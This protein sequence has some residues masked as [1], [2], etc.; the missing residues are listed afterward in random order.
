MWTQ[1]SSI[2]LLTTAFMVLAVGIESLIVTFYFLRAL[3]RLRRVEAF[4]EQSCDVWNNTFTICH[5]CTKLMFRANASKVMHTADG[6][7]YICEA[8]KDAEL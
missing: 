1:F 5:N 7:K 8:C 4:A 6:S 3:A 2:L